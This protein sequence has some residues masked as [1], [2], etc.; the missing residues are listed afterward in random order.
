MPPLSPTARISLLILGWL[1]ILVGLLGLVLPGLQGLV[2]I[3][4]GAA[5]LSLVSQTMLDALRYLFRPWPRA[6]R[7][8]LRT[9]R[10]VQHWISRSRG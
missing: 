7:F 4:L 1:L 10:R 8:V 9:R 5:A 3:F 2:T 6:W